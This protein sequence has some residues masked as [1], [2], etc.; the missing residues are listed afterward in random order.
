MPT[1][2]LISID[3]PAIPELPHYSSIA[4]RIEDRLQSHR[5]LFQDVF[6][7]LSG[8]ILHLANKELEGEDGGWFAGLLMDWPEADDDKEK[9]KQALAALEDA[10]SNATTE[11]EKN[12]A[13]SA[14]E[15]A[16]FL[17]VPRDRTL[18]FLPEVLADIKD[19]M[20]RLLDASPQHRM[21]FSSDYQFG[22]ERREG[23]EVTLTEFFDL[24]DRRLL[25]YNSLFYVR[26]GD[27]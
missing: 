18:I 15:T 27:A 20:Q 8:V 5:G 9:D 6:D 11:E 10:V 16:C 14:Y 2:E 24:H 17:L 23:G 22:G 25:L 26:S 3:C 19:L 13:L 1:I 21:T 12:R 7:T 4:Y